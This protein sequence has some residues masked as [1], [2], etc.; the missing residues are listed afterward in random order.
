MI[1]KRTDFE[2]V[3]RRRQLK[4]SDFQGYLEFEIN[5]DRLQ[6]LRAEKFEKDRSKDSVLLH[7]SVLAASI[8]HIAYIFERAIRR[9]P[10]DMSFWEDFIAFLKL[11]KSNAM[12]NRVYGKALSL[13][14]TNVNFWLQAS[15]HE[16]ENNGNA[17][18]A[19]VLLQRGIRS[20]KGSS[21]LWSRY[22][23]LELWSA[24]RVTERKKILDIGDED[25]AADFVEA[26]PLVVF[27]HAIDSLH[28]GKASEGS[29]SKTIHPALLQMHKSCEGIVNRLSLCK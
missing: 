7:R 13:H 16:L 9:F 22:F 29:T 10:S 27:K 6:T 18:A 11:K 28:E 23:D 20:N 24:L 1:K 15:I 5:L 25:E 26:A 4:P 17:H 14:P 2:Y 21:E 3:L 12:L 8:R 19:R